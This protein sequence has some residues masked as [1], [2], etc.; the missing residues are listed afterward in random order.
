MCVYS[1]LDLIQGTT[2]WVGRSDRVTSTR[3]RISDVPRISRHSTST[4]GPV[5]FY[6]LPNPPLVLE[7][8]YPPL[9]GFFFSPP[10]TFLFF[11]LNEKLHELKGDWNKKKK[12]KR[13]NHW[14]DEG[15]ECPKKK[16][17]RELTKQSCI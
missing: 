1:T 3:G 14:S 10:K 12:K 13:L 8:K 17:K 7:A 6:P 2:L 9:F 4:E 15:S 16:K 11:F 5:P